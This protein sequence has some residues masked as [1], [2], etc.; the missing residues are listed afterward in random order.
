MKYCMEVCS[1]NNI[2]FIVLDRPN[3]I[4][5]VDISGPMLKKSNIFGL[6]GIHNLPIRHAMTPGELAQL[7]KSDEKMNLNLQII[8]KQPQYK[9]VRLVSI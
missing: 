1:E 7:F 8:K 6:A 3:P 4:N 2:G 9:L 5:G